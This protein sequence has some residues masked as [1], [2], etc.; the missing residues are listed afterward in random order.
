MSTTPVL[1]R[2]D[3]KKKAY[4]HSLRPLAFYF[5]PAESTVDYSHLLLSLHHAFQITL[6]LPLK[7]DVGIA[8][9]AAAIASA[10]RGFNSLPM[11]G[12]SRTLIMLADYPHIIREVKNNLNLLKTSSLI[13]QWRRL[14]A[15]EDDKDEEDF[16]GNFNE[17]MVMEKIRNLHIC[18]CASTTF[19][20]C[21][22]YPQPANLANVGPPTCST[23]TVN[24]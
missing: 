14:Q 8:D 17:V 6:E 23:N 18:R 2:W 24:C 19:N 16:V 4:V 7:I 1:R 20:L 11:W 21:H 3:Q 22:H 12:T 5:C 15:E 9:R 10:L 13:A